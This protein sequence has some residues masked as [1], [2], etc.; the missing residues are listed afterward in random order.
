MPAP[1]A[2]T[3]ADFA[4]R[5]ARTEWWLR[6]TAVIVVI[7]FGVMMAADGLTW[8]DIGLLAFIAVV[9]TIMLGVVAFA[10]KTLVDLATRE[11]S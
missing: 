7:G 8:T 9:L 6:L 3:T 1:E 2:P 5:M 4:R 10:R 11:R